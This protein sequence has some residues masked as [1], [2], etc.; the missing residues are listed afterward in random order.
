[1]Q[2]REAKKKSVRNQGG[3]A[4]LDSLKVS[5]LEE[6]NDNHVSIFFFRQERG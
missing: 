5:S 4:L 3:K 2:T 6:N 1:M